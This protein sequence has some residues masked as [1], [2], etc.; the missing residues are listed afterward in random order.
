MPFAFHDP[1]GDRGIEKR[2]HRGYVGGRWE[3]IGKLQ[4]NFL[5]DRGLKPNSFLLDIA[6]GSLRLGVKAIPYLEPSH[7]LGIEKESGLVKAGIEK[8]LEPRLREIKLPNIVISNSF[9]FKKLGQQADFAIAQSLFTHL[10]PRLINLCFKNLYLHLNDGGVFYATYYRTDQKINNP[11][12][13]HDHGH[14]A[15]TQDEMICFGETNG[16]TANYIGDWNHPRNQVIVEYKK[17]NNGFCN[18]I[19]ASQKT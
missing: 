2:G 7:Y 11:K 18:A 19:T 5:L 3:E 14:F 12:R 8:E 1:E 10:P 16:F 4:F 6:C 17:A 15:Y 9:E 13:S